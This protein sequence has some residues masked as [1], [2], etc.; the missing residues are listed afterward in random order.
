[1]RAHEWGKLWTG[2]EAAKR[3]Q[4]MEFNEYQGVYPGSTS[5]LSACVP[6]ASFFFDLSN[7]IGG[8]P[9]WKKF[10]GTI[11]WCSR[12]DDPPHPSCLPLRQGI[13]PCDQWR[14][15]RCRRKKKDEHWWTMRLLGTFQ[16]QYSWQISL[17]F[18][19]S[20]CLWTSPRIAGL[21][22]ILDW[23]KR[24]VPGTAQEQS[25]TTTG[26]KEF[27]FFVF[28]LH[29]QI[30]NLVFEWNF[31]TKGP[32]KTQSF[33]N[34][35]TLHWGKKVWNHSLHLG[36]SFRQTQ[37]SD[38]WFYILLN[39]TIL[40]YISTVSLWLLL[41]YISTYA[42][43]HTHIYTHTQIR[44]HTYIHTSIHTYIH[45]SIIHTYIRTYIHTYIHP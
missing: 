11:W 8:R 14:W 26:F 34:G 41:I 40:H 20:I 39:P 23:R 45:T 44:M 24:V 6:I 12:G 42:Y 32:Y 10:S 3:Q 18:L 38:C 9:K 22:M 19:S 31:E 25:T 2:T 7:F 4:N 30:P 29:F 27:F 33:Q 21:C 17:Q 43:T 16:T 5:E 37:I 1:M 15:K 36:T 28:Q 13:W 35:Q